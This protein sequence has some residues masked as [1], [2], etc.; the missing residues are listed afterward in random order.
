MLLLAEALRARG[1]ENVCAFRAG[2][3]L[4]RRAAAAGLEVIEFAPRGEWDVGAAR[5]LRR[6]LAERPPDLLHAHDGHAVAMALLAARGRTP[7]VASRRV[8]LP[9]RKNPFSRLKLARVARWL[10]VSVAA[11]D[12]LVRA[13][14]DPGRIA[15]VPS[16]IETSGAPGAADS[17][18]PSRPQLRPRLGLP[19]E[20]FVILT[21]GRLEPLKG[22][23]TFVEACAL[24]A[25]LRDTSWVVAGEGP[26]RP[27]LECLASAR[28]VVDRVVFAGHVEDLSRHMAEFQVCV[29]TSFSEGLGTVLLDA[30]AAGVPVVA[31]DAGGVPE[32]VSDGVAGFLAPVGDARSVAEAVR[33]LYLNPAQRLEMG[34]QARER[35]AAFRIERTAELTLEGYRAVLGA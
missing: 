27:F 2:A 24:A 35:A 20:S 33:E 8:A 9:P 26:D 1:H 3:P 5:R 34:R 22:Q 32:V 6:A 12:A 23:R 19:S 21:A 16:G 10:A 25:D 31:C 14:V 30:L 29:L 13:G 4:A 7:V 28:G 17:D 11:R 15:V 18:S